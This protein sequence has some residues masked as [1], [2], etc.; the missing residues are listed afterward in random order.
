MMRIERSHNLGQQEAMRRIDTFVDALILRPLPA[1]LTIEAPCK[2]WTANVMQ[3]SFKA[4]KG[5]LGTTITGSMRVTDQAVA[6]ESDLPGILTTFV[7]EHDI[8]VLIN[9]QLDDILGAQT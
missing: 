6:L 3:F 8:Q 5:W 7:P 4:K 1:G 9:Q 2:S